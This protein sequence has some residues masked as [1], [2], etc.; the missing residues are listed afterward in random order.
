MIVGKLTVVSFAY[1]KKSN[2]YMNCKCECGNEKIIRL[3][4]LIKKETNSCGCIKKKFYPQE[5]TAR[6]IWRS[7]YTDCDINIFLIYSQ[8]NCHDCGVAPHKTINIHNK[9]L[10]NKTENKNN[11]YFSY[12]GLDRLDSNF[13]H[14]MDNVVPCC[15]YCN[16][17]KSIRSYSDF[18]IWSESIY[19]NNVNVKNKLK[20]L[21]TNLD[22]NVPIFNS[23]I[24]SAA[25]SMWQGNYK[26]LPFNY[27]LF[28]SQQ[29]CFYCNVAP[30]NKKIYTW[31]RNK[32]NKQDYLFTYNG[33]DRVN[34]NSG[35]IPGNVVPCCIFCNK[36]KLDR[37]IDDFYL[38]ADNLYGNIIKNELKTKINITE[39]Y[40]LIF[41]KISNKIS[42][43]LNIRKEIYDNLV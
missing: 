11:G 32:E 36:A 29:N 25:H 26:E 6:S 24:T 7:C 39:K 9:Y 27:F 13:G 2:Q 19:Y 40:I 3:D 22:I 21:D 10:D 18:I 20:K 43:P 15:F 41:D 5:S 38:W 35:H 4:H 34:N 8:L 28:L 31:H 30:I 23:H 33:I 12:N 37:S 17:A 14:T 1:S 42:F 16:S